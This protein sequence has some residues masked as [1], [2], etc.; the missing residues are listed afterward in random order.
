MDFDLVV[1]GG[2]IAGSTLARPLA[3]HWA[4]MLVL[5]REMAFRDRMRGEQ[6]HPWGVAEAR[7]L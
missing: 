2:G 6:M 1:V 4:R 5:E 3:G 7:G